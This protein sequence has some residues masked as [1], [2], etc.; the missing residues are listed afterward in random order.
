MQKVV[1]VW[2][3]I[4]CSACISLP[5]KNMMHGSIS[6]L[7]EL[8]IPARG[9]V[10]TANLGDRML[11]S[12]KAWDVDCFEPLFSH[13][14]PSLDNGGLRVVVIEKTKICA[15]GQGANT[16]EP[17][18][19]NWFGAQS[20]A[21]PIL[22]EKNKD[23]GMGFFIQ[24]PVVGGFHHVRDLQPSDYKITLGQKWS[25]SEFQQ[26]IEY[27]GRAGDILSFTYSEYSGDVAR[28][29]FTRQ[30]S[31]DLSEGNNMAYKGSRM[32]IISATN[33]EITYRVEKTFE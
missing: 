8:N 12:G 30:F 33:S 5:P 31:I 21:M 18:Y 14:G 27:M 11:F 32:E 23:G 16:F 19:K 22:L 6:E 1:L 2:C 26:S 3:V 4:L 7:R 13:D 24:N 28:P 17:D 29:A 9:E 25:P 10:K 20:F 15:R